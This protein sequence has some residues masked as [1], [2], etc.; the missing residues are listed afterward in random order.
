MS[1]GEKEYEREKRLRQWAKV[2]ADEKFLHLQQT[3]Y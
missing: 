1:I 2:Y 3:Y